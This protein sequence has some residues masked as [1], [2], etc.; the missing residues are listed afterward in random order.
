MELERKQLLSE[1]LSTGARLTLVFSLFSCLLF[2]FVQGSSG[3]GKNS[4][5]A[6]ASSILPKAWGL[7]YIYIYFF[8]FL[9]VGGELQ[10]RAA[11][12]PKVLDSQ[13]AL[14]DMKQ[15]MKALSQAVGSQYQD[16]V[17]I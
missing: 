4:E 9:G 2:V 10:G 11:T 1:E 5:E 14:A 16:K 17:I 8:F 15:R 7:L 6:E 12:A 3:N 13:A